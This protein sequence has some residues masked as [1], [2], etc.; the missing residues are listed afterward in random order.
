[1][2]PCTERREMATKSGARDKGLRSE[3]DR[4]IPHRHFHAERLQR[5]NRKIRR[6]LGNKQ[7][8]WWVVRAG[9]L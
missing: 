7:G 8:G 2:Y 5:T 1:M 4:G 3:E 9:S 6:Q